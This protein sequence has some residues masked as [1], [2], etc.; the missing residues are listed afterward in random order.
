LKRETDLWTT[1]DLRLMDSSESTI[2]LA[3]AKILIV[4]DMPANLQI[5]RGGAGAGRI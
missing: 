2:D 3:G 4:D 1:N 5:L